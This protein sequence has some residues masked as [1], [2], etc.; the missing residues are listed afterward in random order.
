M[1]T[2]DFLLKIALPVEIMLLTIGVFIYGR[3]NERREQMRPKLAK[4]FRVYLAEQNSGNYEIYISGKPSGAYVTEKQLAKLL[5]KSQL[6]LF[7]EDSE[8]VFF[9]KKDRLS[10]FMDKHFSKAPGKKAFNIEQF[11]VQN[12]FSKIY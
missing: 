6:I 10:V 1:K 3:I 4:L 12:E 2:I 11:K 5:D 8:R 9:I 7:K